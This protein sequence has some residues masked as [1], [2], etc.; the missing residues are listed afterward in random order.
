MGQRITTSQAAYLMGVDRRTVC[1][2]TD[3]G[4]LSCVRDEKNYRWLDEDE[5]L[6]MRREDPRTVML[7]VHREPESKPKGRK[8][9]VFDPV[10]TEEL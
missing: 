4:L 2:W 9:R 6:A 10:D 8:R 3:K 1:Y 5:V 7:P